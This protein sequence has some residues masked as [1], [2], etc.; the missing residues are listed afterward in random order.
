[1]QEA[2]VIPTERVGLELDEFLCLVFPERSK[3]FLRSEIRAGRI[4]LDGLHV[5]PSS[6]LRSSQVVLI[7]TD[8]EGWPE[9]QTA[10][11]GPELPILYEDEHL[12]VI[13]KPAGLACEPER[14]DKEKASLA[15]AVLDLARARAARTATT[16][17]LDWR[18]RLVHRLDKDT[19]GVALVA[20]TLEA[21]R[22]ARGAF[23]AGT[24][25]KTYLALV[26]GEYPLQDDAEDRIEFPIAPDE[27][28]SGRMIVDT[29]RG[30][31]ATTIVRVE[32]RFR[33]YTLVACRPLTGRT[34]Q[35]RVHL[36]ERGFPLVVDPAYGRRRAL[37][38]SELKSGYRKKRGQTE[39][40]LIERHTL[41]AARLEFTFLGRKLCFEAPLPLDLSRTLKQL[42]RNRPVVPTGVRSRSAPVRAPGSASSSASGSAS[43][44]VS[45]G[46]VQ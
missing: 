21:E 30:K 10:E 8:A 9:P 23:E 28:R 26:E 29:L 24:V 44:S 17:P 41:H 16:L 32:S 12:L 39:R 46:G 35:I 25:E 36:A 7:Q 18:P 1:V 37:L 40:P 13:D 6:R 45:G 14:W 43:G 38:L 15:S 3:G 34:H 4:L 33:G 11:S 42:A 22:E 20:K 19:T 5:H 27:R 31:P 2:I